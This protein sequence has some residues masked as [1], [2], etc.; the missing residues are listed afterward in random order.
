MTHSSRKIGSSTRLRPI[1]TFS[2]WLVMETPFL[3]KFWLKEHLTHMTNQH[4]SLLF[5]F[6]RPGNMKHVQYRLEFFYLEVF[7]IWQTAGFVSTFFYLVYYF[8]LATQLG[9]FSSRQLMETN[10][11]CI[12]FLD[13]LRHLKLLT[14]NL[15][16]GLSGNSATFGLQADSLCCSLKKKFSNTAACFQCWCC[17]NLTT[18]VTNQDV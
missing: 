5:L 14:S 16:N 18:K 10:L 17:S 7:S 8:H 11:I 2:T 12:F 15:L 3:K 13:F 9:L 4:F 6:S 1:L